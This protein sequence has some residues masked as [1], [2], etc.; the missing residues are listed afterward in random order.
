MQLFRLRDGSQMAHVGVCECLYFLYSVTLV[1]TAGL[2]AV[3]VGST[4]LVLT[5][6]V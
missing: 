2:L 4:G 1:V 3:L 5:R 6:L